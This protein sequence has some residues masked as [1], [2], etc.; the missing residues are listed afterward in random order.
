[1]LGKFETLSDLQHYANSYEE[2]PKADDEFWTNQDFSSFHMQR[3]PGLKTKI[4]NWIGI[5][6]SMYW[7]AYTF[8]QL[9]DTAIIT[10]QKVSGDTVSYLRVP[11]GSRILIW[12]DLHGAFHSLVRDLTYLH[13]QKIIDE[14]LNIIA[15]NTYFVFNGDAIDRSPFTLETFTVLLNLLKKNPESVFWT[16]GTHEANNYWQHSELNR[17]LKIRAKH[18]SYEKTP[19]NTKVSNFFYTLPLAVYF[20]LEN[21]RSEVIRISH[22][23]RSNPILDEQNMGALFNTTGKTG[24]WHYTI[25]N[26]KQIPSKIDVKVIIQTENWREGIR[27]QLGLGLQDQDQGSISWAVLSSPITVHQKYLNFYYDAFAT[28]DLKKTINDSTISL[29]NQHAQK[30]DGF[31]TD[32]VYRLVT[33]APKGT[34]AF[35]QPI[36]NELWIGS[37][38]ALIMGVPLMGSRTRDGASIRINEENQCGGL[39]GT[40]LR[41]VVKN[42][43]YVPNMALQN[44]NDFIE[45]NITLILLP[46]GSPTLSAYL[47]YIRTKKV[48]VLFPITGGPTFRSPEL[49]GIIHLRASY[50]DEVQALLDHLINNYK[51]HK[52]AFFYQD[53]AYGKGPLQAAHKILKGKD[54]TLTDVPY[55][56]GESNFELEVQKIATAQPDALGFFST[57]QA[58]QELIRQIGI[59]AL[60]SKQLFGI[61][62]LGEATFRQFLKEVNLHLIFGA[63]VPSPYVSEREIVKQYREAIKRNNKFYDI[64][65]LEAYIATSLLIHVLHEIKLPYTNDKILAYLEN[66]KD[67]NFKGIPLSFNPEQR[68]LA[69]TVWIETGETTLWIESKVH[70]KSIA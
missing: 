61:S 70:Q 3:L 41:F 21:N 59:T 38:M 14:N 29:T 18:I 66:I 54:F 24:I 48:C 49:K 11:D 16:R 19:L 35:T 39:D 5:N 45:K 30:K 20:G 27:T 56:R 8:A 32:K 4:L 33:G 36:T 51:T 12:G 62:F 40:L 26:E 53:D 65:S 10:R 44:I 13:E 52:F 37:S 7:S 6:S 9:L 22:F 43:N 58:S 15:P 63:V 55:T 64:F 67:F 42:D 17:E 57:A 1:M 46:V 47:D 69:R 28:I 31:K 60:S 25:A 23:G 34:K 2:H 68:S 50:P